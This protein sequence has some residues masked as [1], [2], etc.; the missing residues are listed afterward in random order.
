MQDTMDE[1]ISRSLARC[2]PASKDMQC[3]TYSV[4]DLQLDYLRE[5][6]SHNEGNQS[7]SQLHKV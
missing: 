5:S 1:L 6:C 7:L 2:L 3:E 4:H